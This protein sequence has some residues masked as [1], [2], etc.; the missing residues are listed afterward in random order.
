MKFE[1][2][3]T[4]VTDCDLSISLNTRKENCSLP[5][6]ALFGQRKFYSKNGVTAHPSC[7]PKVNSGKWSKVSLLCNRDNLLKFKDHCFSP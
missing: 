5:K 2:G 6:A 3:D 4:V 1:A 7:L